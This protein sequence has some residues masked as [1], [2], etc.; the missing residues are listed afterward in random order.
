MHACMYREEICLSEDNIKEGNA[1]IYQICSIMKYYIF[2]FIV[3]S[4]G[5]SLASE[6]RKACRHVMG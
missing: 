1:F 2:Y 3:L 6:I 5:L 4:V